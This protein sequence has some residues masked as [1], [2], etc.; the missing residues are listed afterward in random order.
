MRYPRPGKQVICFP[1]IPETIRILKA[2][3]KRL[4]G[5]KFAVPKY[6]KSRSARA[7]ELGV[8]EK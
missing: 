1:R 2:F 6:G 4:A 5:A 7:G 3:H 8:G